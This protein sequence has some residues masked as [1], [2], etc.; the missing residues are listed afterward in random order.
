V[1]GWY[2]RLPMIV[3]RVD[4]PASNVSFAF[5]IRRIAAEWSR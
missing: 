2:C 3:I 1:C 4:S 5:A